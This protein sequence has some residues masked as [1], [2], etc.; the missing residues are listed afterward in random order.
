MK[1]KIYI[2]IIGGLGNQMFQMAHA[3]SLL[4]EKEVNICPLDFTNC[5]T[6]INRK[7]QLDCFNLKPYKISLL[8]KLIILLRIKLSSYLIK[9]NKNFHLRVFHEKEFKEYKINEFNPQQFNVIFGYW[10]SEIYFEKSKKEIRK[11]F[12]FPKIIDSHKKNNFVAIHVRLGDYIADSRTRNF[13]LVCDRDWYLKAVKKMEELINNPQFV[14]FSDNYYEAKKIFGSKVNIYFNK[15]TSSHKPWLDMKRISEFKH[16]I[17]SNSSYSW[18]ASYL[19]KDE[20]SLVIAPKYW[21]PNKKT[22]NLP[23]YR[24]EWFLL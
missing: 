11:L 24:K 2:P 18:W 8:S 19:G 7:W 22:K 15:T 6:R 1:K 3:I 21:Y 16:F 23:I 17:L 13:H 10:Q 20:S 5:F 12:Y 14:V 9:I 4:N